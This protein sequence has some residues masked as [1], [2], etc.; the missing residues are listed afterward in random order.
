MAGSFLLPSPLARADWIVIT[1]A[2]TATTI[3]EIFVEDDQVRV[4]LEIGVEDFGAFQNLLPDELLDRIQPDHRPFEERM[5]LLFSNDLTISA[6]GGLPMA[7]AVASMQ[8]RP[9]LKRDELTG[10]PLPA[11]IGDV[12]VEMVLIATLIYSFDSQPLN[13]TIKAPS[14]DDGSKNANVGFML[15]HKGIPVNDFRYLSGEQTVDLDWEDPWYSRFR[16]RNLWR[17]FNAPINVFLYIEPYEVRVE[18]VARPTDL[19]Q[20]NDFGIADYD[21]LPVEIQ[22]V[23]LN[24]IGEFLGEHIDLMIDGESVTPVLDRINFLNR[25]LRTSTIIDPPVELDAGSAILGAIFVFPTSGL[26][27]TAQVTWDL[28]SEKYPRVRAAATDEAG[29]QP[30]FL[31]PEDNELKWINFLTNPTI[32]TLVDV[33]SPDSLTKLSVPLITVLCLLLMLPIGLRKVRLSRT[34]MLVSTGLLLVVAVLGWSYARVQVPNPAARMMTISDEK[35]SD[36]VSTLL[37]NIYVAFNFRDE[38]VIYDALGRSV[39]GDLLT[40]IYLETQKSL[41]LQSQGGARVKVKAIDLIGVEVE[42]LDGEIGFTALA[43]WNVRGSVGHWG[44]IHERINQYEARLTVKPIDGEW[45][46]VD[47]ELLQEERITSTGRSSHSEIFAVSNA[48]EI[49]S[50]T[51]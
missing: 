34:Q 46:I 23:L 39:S 26:P 20:W 18:V 45:K 31:T 24:N 50:P 5:P 17:Q 41:E 44:H 36:V 33:E 19:Q 35:A 37:R 43:T 21:V 7:G 48:A 51:L 47:L 42:N 30:F 32:P 14:G 15:Y 22:A 1:R 16:H 27:E 13:L 40:D 11:D 9:R 12:D 28:Y 25:S 49:L 10:E 8:F 29:S 2:M 6:E 4:E 38:G 3:A